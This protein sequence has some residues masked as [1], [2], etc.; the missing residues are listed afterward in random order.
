MDMPPNSWQSMGDYLRATA[1]DVGEKPRALLIIS[2][3]WEGERALVTT[4]EQPGLLFDYYGFPEHTYQ[5]T[6]AAPGS[7]RLAQ[8]V[9]QLLDEAGIQS[10]VDPQRDLDHGVFVPFKLIYP[11]ADIPIVQL[12]LVAGLDPAQHLR[13][14][15]AIASLRDEGVLI[16]GSGMSY[17]NLREFM[18]PSAASTDASSRF[19]E[20]L[21]ANVVGDAKQRD[22]A[23]ATWKSA[24][25]ALACHPRAEHLLPLMVVAGAALEDRGR[26]AFND[27]V[28]GKSVS[29]YRFG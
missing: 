7:P 17:H 5:L 24:P 21:T 8:R 11:E 14:G 15:R 27:R 3:H 4:A 23:L 6:Y 26:L 9:T 29:G 13:I 18:R 16:V 28:F 25:D 22:E 10:A 1:A 12:S 19:D 2:A 20:W